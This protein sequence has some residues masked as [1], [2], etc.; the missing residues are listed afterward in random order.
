MKHNTVNL[1]CFS[2]NK[3]T[4]FYIEYL[5]IVIQFLLNLETPIKTFSYIIYTDR[6]SSDFLN[7]LFSKLSLTVHI[8]VLSSRQQIPLSSSAE[9]EIDLNSDVKLLLNLLLP[10]SS[11]LNTLDIAYSTNLEGVKGIL[12]SLVNYVKTNDSHV[13]EPALDTILYKQYNWNRSYGRVLFHKDSVII[14]TWGRGTYSMRAPRI[15]EATWHNYSHVLLFDA[16]FQ[17]FVSVLSNSLELVYGTQDTSLKDSIPRMEFESKAK[18]NLVYFCAFHNKGYIDLLYYLLSSAL[19]FSNLETLDFLVFTSEAFRPLI[20]DIS[21]KLNIPIQIQ[22]FKFTTMHEAG[23]ARL[24]IFNY[25]DIDL[26]EKILYLDTDI[27]VQNDIS[28]LFQLPLEEKVYAIQEYDINGEGHGAWFF[29]FHRF[30]KN[31]PA[32]NSGVLLFKNT[33]KIRY[34]FK[35]IQRHIENLKKSGSILPNCMDQSFIVYS[36]FTHNTYDSQLMKRYIYLSEHIP[37][38]FPSSY[39]DLTFTHFV[40][41]IGNTEHKKSRMMSHFK[42]LLNHYKTA[43]NCEAPD[44]LPKLHICHSTLEF[45]ED[46]YKYLDSHTVETKTHLLKFNDSYSLFVGFNKESLETVSNIKQG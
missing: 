3:E 8:E 16:S 12:N 10:D 46:S 20:E 40:W 9:L 13:Q 30:D 17:R 43:R 15:V 28:R 26:Y 27:I 11:I 18:K 23:C 6:E 2:L 35:T 45:K 14:T 25:E 1:S 32:I 21:R 5:L 4:H 44:G 39:S 37:P 36:L 29:D 31:T 24:F 34:L 33:R 22:I 41:P 42:D 19:V 7:G 38:P